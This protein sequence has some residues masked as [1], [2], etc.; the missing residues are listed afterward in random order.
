VEIYLHSSNTPS[1][2][3]ASL[4]TGTTLPYFYFTFM[5]SIYCMFIYEYR[6]T[7][8]LVMKLFTL[9][10]KA[11]VLI[12]LRRGQFHKR[13]PNWGDH[14]IWL[15]SLYFKK[16]NHPPFYVDLFFIPAN[17]SLRA[18]INSCLSHH[19]PTEHGSLS[20]SGSECPIHILHN[21][22]HTMHVSLFDSEWGGGGSFTF[23]YF[24][25]EHEFMAA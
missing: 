14:E 19:L 1:R 25:V 24:R 15:C 11:E 6:H 10:N 7:H 3:G 2:H 20:D 18:S 5:S 17:E 16:W 9:K 8:L 23:T 13:T 22:P 4:S 12:T 21:V